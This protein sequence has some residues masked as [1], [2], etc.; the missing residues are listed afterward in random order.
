MAGPQVVVFTMTG[1]QHCAGVK[2]YLE[3]KGIAFSERNLL[4]DDQA[5]ADFRELGY[6]STPVTIV[7]DEAV[8]GFDRARMDE[9][10]GNLA[11]EDA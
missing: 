7:G 3:E 8:I 10:F 1:C 6:R 5:M 9:V 4:V 11:G 2:A